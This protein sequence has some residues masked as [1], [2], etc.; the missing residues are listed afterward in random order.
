M[1]NNKVVSDKELMKT[2]NRK[3]DRTGT[4]SQSKVTATVQRGTVTVSGKL[5]YENRRTPIVKAISSVAG[6][7]QVI[8]RLVGPPR[9]KVAAG[10]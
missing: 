3:L 4:G 7:R 5:Q 9:N 8:D 10:N 6:V 2:I 1:F